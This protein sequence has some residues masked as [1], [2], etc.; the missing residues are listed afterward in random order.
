MRRIRSA[1][2]PSVEITDRAIPF[3]GISA[4]LAA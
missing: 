1:A 4:P 2:V 3:T